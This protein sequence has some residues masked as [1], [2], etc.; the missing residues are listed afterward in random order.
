MVNRSTKQ[1]L[2]S[3]NHS[4]ELH[5]VKS[6][7]FESAFIPQVPMAHWISPRDKWIYLETGRTEGLPLRC[8]RLR[9]NQLQSTQMAPKRYPWR[10]VRRSCGKHPNLLRKHK[11]E[12]LKQI[13]LNIIIFRRCCLCSKICKLYNHL[14]LINVLLHTIHI[15][16]SIAVAFGALQ[17]PFH[18]QLNGLSDPQSAGPMLGNHPY[19][20][21]MTIGIVR[22]E[23][24]IKTLWTTS[25]N[26]TEFIP[27]KT[28]RVRIMVLKITMQAHLGTAPG[29]AKKNIQQHWKLGMW[30]N[31]AIRQTSQ[32]WSSPNAGLLGKKKKRMLDLVPMMGVS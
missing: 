30:M 15:I 31:V 23:A 14:S 16:V 19:S 8:S 3:W 12:G 28:S 21:A 32:L 27:P 24:I 18:L 20:A 10:L 26:T 2:F 25:V 29:M 4:K 1:I 13:F 5:K 22:K 9:C 11:S 7:M 6:N 17:H